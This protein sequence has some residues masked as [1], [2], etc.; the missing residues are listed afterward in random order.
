MAKTTA[1][2]LEAM[3]N[4]IVSCQI[5][6]EAIDTLESNYLFT[7]KFKQ[8]AKTFLKELEKVINKFY[9]L[10]GKIHKIDYETETQ[11]YKAI[12]EYKEFIQKYVK[13]RTK[14]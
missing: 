13:E 12:D 5:L 6:I 9:D 10:E 14:S 8:T 4:A 3:V 2:Q 7:Q 1:E 11:F